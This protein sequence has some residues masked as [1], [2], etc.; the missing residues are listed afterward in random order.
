VALAGE[1]RVGELVHHGQLRTAAESRLGVELGEARIAVG[2]RAGGQHFKVGQLGGGPGPPVP[3]HLGHDGIGTGAP[4]GARS[5]QHRVGLPHSGSDPE[6]GAQLP[7]AGHRW[8]HSD[9]IRT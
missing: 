6:V 5:P 9:M 7:P 1:V 8:I 3:L 2:D 4:P